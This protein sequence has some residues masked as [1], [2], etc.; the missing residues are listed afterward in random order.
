MSDITK[1]LAKIEIPDYAEDEKMNLE[2]GVTYRGSFKIKE[3]GQIV[4]R[5]YK[6]GAKPGNLSKVVEG[7]HHVIF[8]SKNLLRIVFTLPKTNQEQMKQRFKEE[9]FECY[10]DIC[11][12]QL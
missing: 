12:L 5:P 8:E 7:E 9:F 2:V 3:N 6:E 4:V 10:K 1:E 11:D